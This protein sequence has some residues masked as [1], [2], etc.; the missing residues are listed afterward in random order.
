MGSK[1]ESSQ[2]INHYQK[3]LKERIYN[4]DVQ[5]HR[6]NRYV[7]QKGTV[8]LQGM[9]GYFC[10]KLYMEQLAEEESATGE[11]G[12]TWVSSSFDLIFDVKYESSCWKIEMQFQSDYVPLRKSQ[13]TQQDSPSSFP[14]ASLQGIPSCCCICSSS[15]E[16][17]EY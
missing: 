5:I 1:G 6:S 11:C 9:A 10:W 16:T 4:L 3:V 7:R 17:K 15:F 12:N 13:L 14:R 2:Q 8:S